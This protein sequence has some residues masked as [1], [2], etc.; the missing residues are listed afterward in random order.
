M[1][2]CG[3]EARGEQ[4]EGLVGE[5]RG[6]AATRSGSAGAARRN[7]RAPGMQR[8]LTVT[9]A[10]RLQNKQCKQASKPHLDAAVDVVE[11][12]R[13]ALAGA[14]GLRGAGNEQEESSDAWQVAR[15]RGNNLPA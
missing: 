6:R 12:L 11:A 5:A 13:G 14:E 4:V 2:S 7:D 15:M 9:H 3:Q 10:S 1:A 8:A